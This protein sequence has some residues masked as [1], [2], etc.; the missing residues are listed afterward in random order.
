MSKNMGIYK[1][2]DEL[3]DKYLDLKIGIDPGKSPLYIHKT[4]C[5]K[6]SHTPS[7]FSAEAFINALL[8]CIENNWNSS[9]RRISNLHP[10][11]ENW[12]FEKKEYIDKRSNLSPEK[13]L[14][15]AIISVV[16]MDWANQ[17][18]TASG[19]YDSTKDKHRS[20]DLVHRLE[21]KCY[22]VIE[23]KIASD[24]PLKAAMEVLFYGV[25]Y[26]FARLHPSLYHQNHDL[27][28]ADEILLSVL[29]PCE[30]YKTYNL[31]W[32]ESNLCSGLQRF[33]PTRMVNCKIS[34]AFK[35]FPSWFKWSVDKS[36]ET[37]MQRYLLTVIEN[38]V[39][40]LWSE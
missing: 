6:L 7:Q 20:I 12:R 37:D 10:S 17:V 27:L 2:I 39:P 18:P 32:L 38:V 40:V 21:T 8:T 35:A 29:A 34:F 30:Y 25:L 15:K 16:N 33:L 26:I 23:L 14:E 31:K 3:I 24:N 19:L 5:T 36:N 13:T 11:K 9:P 28:H 22:E 1:G 4:S